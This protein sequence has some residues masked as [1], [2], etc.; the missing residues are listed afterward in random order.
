MNDFSDI[1]FAGV[2]PN[3]SYTHELKAKPVLPLGNPVNL[4]AATQLRQMGEN[5]QRVGRTCRGVVESMA[6]AFQGFSV[7]TGH[8]CREW[9]NGLRL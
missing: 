3:Y 4:G 5:F 8:V 6:D 2:G 1:D 7:A 9:Q